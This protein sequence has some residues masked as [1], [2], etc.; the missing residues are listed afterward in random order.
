MHALTNHQH[1]R[2]KPGSGGRKLLQHLPAL[3]TAEQEQLHLP[4][5]FL[6]TP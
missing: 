3:S 2:G 6:R 1:P 4:W 5:A